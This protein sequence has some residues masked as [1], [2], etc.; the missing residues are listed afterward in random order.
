M[1]DIS[2]DVKALCASGAPG[3]VGTVIIGVGAL[4]LILAVVFIVRA[5]CGESDSI[6]SARSRAAAK[7]VEPSPFSDF[8][9]SENV[10]LDQSF[11]NRDDALRFLSDSAC[12][13]GLASSS[14]ALFKSFVDRESEGTTGMMDGFAVPHAKDV[15]V[16]EPAIVVVKAPQGIPDWATMDTEPVRIAIALLIP[17][18]G[19]G[20]AHLRILSKLA[21][22]LMDS[23][24]RKLVGESKDPR[25]I[26]SA[27]NGRLA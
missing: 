5:R 12:R 7:P 11:D 20:S 16:P 13:L 17:G 10:F 18:A 2:M 8:V 4:V 23:R 15:S 9:K 3:G 24:F 25:E 14:D 26:A 1:N 19:A 21:E 6:S 27:I 22:A